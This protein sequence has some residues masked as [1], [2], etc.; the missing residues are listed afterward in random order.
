[1]IPIVYA[2]RAFLNP[3]EP[4]FLPLVLIEIV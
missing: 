4:C 2:S 3:A 1:M